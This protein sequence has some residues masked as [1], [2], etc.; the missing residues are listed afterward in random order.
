ME[1]IMSWD[2]KLG[3]F[4]VLA[5]V[6]GTPITTGLAAG[7]PE[8]L[9][10]IQFGE[11]DVSGLHCPGLTWHIDRAVQPDKTAILNGPIWYTDGSGQSFAQGTGQADGHFT[12]NVKTTSGDGPAGT[13]T[14]QRMPDGSVDAT[15]VGHPCF[16]GTVHLAPGQTSAKM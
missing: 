14:G 9:M 11:R 3:A 12:L 16:A 4:F 13:I 6:V 1:I 15:A 2:K 8:G 5:A 10:N 7:M